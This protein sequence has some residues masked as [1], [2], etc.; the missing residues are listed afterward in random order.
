MSSTS[1][2]RAAAADLPRLFL[3][4]NSDLGLFNFLH[5]FH[6]NTSLSL[7]VF[8]Q[9]RDM[10]EPRPRYAVATLLTNDSYLPGALTCIH[11]LL[12]VEEADKT[13]DHEDRAPFETLC[14]VTPATVSVEAIKL[15]KSHFDKVVYCEP[16]ESRST[17]ELA[18]LGAS[19]IQTCLNPC[20]AL[21]H[22][23]LMLLQA[24]QS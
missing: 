19:P 17:K 23:L 2:P 6:S 1:A 10:A 11:S 4:F 5:P 22:H 9:Q 7:C 15:L 16:I 13:A 21:V 20:S 3:Q 18:L 8:P 24:A 14:L 12:D